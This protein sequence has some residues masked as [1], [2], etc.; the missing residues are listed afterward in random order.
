MKTG[1]S[2]G[3]IRKDGKSYRGESQ[4]RNWNKREKTSKYKSEIYIKKPA[5]PGVRKE[6]LEI[7]KKRAIKIKKELDRNKHKRP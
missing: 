2:S 5:G 7:E 3:R 4:A 1:V 6:I